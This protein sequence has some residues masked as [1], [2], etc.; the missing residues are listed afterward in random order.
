LSPV[1][2]RELAWTDD[3]GFNRGYGHVVNDE[4]GLEGFRKYIFEKGKERHVQGEFASI[5]AFDSY[6]QDDD[7]KLVINGNMKGP[8]V[9]DFDGTGD[10]GAAL[11]DAIKLVKWLFDM[12]TD[13]QAVR[14][15]FSGAKG[16][17]VIIHESVFGATASP[18]MPRI[19]R[20]L[21]LSISG[22]LGLKTA[23]RKI[24]H[25]SRILRL[26]RS[27]NAK[28]K[29]FKIPL[30]VQQLG[31]LKVEEIKRT[32]SSDK[33]SET[34]YGPGDPCLAEDFRNAARRVKEKAEAFQEMDI[35]DIKVFQNDCP[36]I[37]EVR[38]GVPEGLRNEALYHIALN[39]KFSGRSKTDTLAFLVAWN[40]KL[41]TPLQPHEI[42]ST[43]DSVFTR[44]YKWSCSRA[45]DCGLNCDPSKCPK[46]KTSALLTNF[47][48]KN[49]LL[50]EMVAS[51]D[52][53][54]VGE[55]DTRAV[56]LALNVG[57]QSVRIS[58][59]SSTG[60]NSLVDAVLD[61]FPN[62]SYLK[63][64]GWSDKAIRYLPPNIG[65]LYIAEMPHDE[66]SNRGESMAEFDIKL[67]ISEGGFTV[68]FV[69][70]DQEGGFIS[71]TKKTALK[72][73]ILTSTEVT[74]APQLQNRI[75]ELETDA[76]AQTTKEVIRR[77][78]ERFT[79]M[80]RE[81][82]V[83]E[84]KRITVRN[85]IRLIMDEA[86]P[87]GNVIVPFAD[88]PSMLSFFSPIPRARRDADKFM[89]L[90][91]AL[92]RVHYSQLPSINRDDEDYIIATPEIF[93]LA[94]MIGRKA[95]TTTFTGIT[96]RLKEA[97][98]KCMELSALSSPINK[99]TLSGH[100]GSSP[101]TANNRLEQL[102]GAG[103][104]EIDSRS[105]G[106]DP[107]FRKS[108]LAESMIGAAVRNDVRKVYDELKEA[109]V[110]RA[111][112]LG[113]DHTVLRHHY[114][115]PFDQKRCDKWERVEQ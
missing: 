16:F 5:M 10:V 74:V 104:L 72:N 56:L 19:Y 102:V 83:L 37:E 99:I 49:D 101:R 112:V 36:C 40:Q 85:S 61:L 17:H 47:L 106:K 95:L 103:L 42:N 90:I 8:L 12:G 97:F 113:Y 33:V 15:Y 4:I 3:N 88:S 38:A 82:F 65:T 96:D 25:A 91:T 64:M 27:M 63:I 29:L 70:S 52:D 58:G 34:V 76:S 24:Y 84:A 14:V 110:K 77:K 78:L 31:K 45:R 111:K 9:F 89:G 48:E 32:A 62:D 108:K 1:F 41:G 26:P 114:V 18:D 7:G 115:N 35:P 13:E 71:K 54:V 46:Y 75:W 80:K 66:M 55:R 86:P 94:Y 107:N 28:T 105:E 69:V 11:K 81:R 98:R 87:V 59:D 20:D 21:A 92:A 6:T 43:V 93:L 79:M 73:V 50:N 57:E 68:T 60:K 51:L 2:Y 30:N 44:S 53:K 67:M 39:D 100:I 109:Y 23:D 22:A